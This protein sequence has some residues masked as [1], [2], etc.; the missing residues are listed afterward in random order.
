MMLGAR[1]LVLIFDPTGVLAGIPSIAHGVPTR[2]RR[3]TQRP[4]RTL[5]EFTAD[6]GASSGSWAPVFARHLTH[7]SPEDHIYS[8]DFFS[9]LYIQSHEHLL[10]YITVY[11][12]GLRRMRGASPAKYAFRQARLSTSASIVRTWDL[13]KH[14]RLVRSG[15]DR[16]CPGSVAGPGE[17]KPARSCQLVSLRKGRNQ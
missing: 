16:F 1:V 2:Y 6:C 12:F 5:T 4:I 15:R 8:A 7:A 17:W 10:T 11:D 3:A 9:G 14:G 13:S